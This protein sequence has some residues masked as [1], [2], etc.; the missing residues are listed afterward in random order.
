MCNRR[1]S[2]NPL[3]LVLMVGLSTC[4]CASDARAETSLH[5]LER[6]AK[7]VEKKAGKAVVKA[8]A[9]GLEVSFVGAMGVAYVA[10]ELVRHSDEEDE[11]A[12]LVN[13]EL[14]PEKPKKPANLPHPAAS[15]QAT[16]KPT[17]VLPVVPTAP[18]P[19]K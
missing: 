1:A 11:T 16:A 3:L 17:A 4:V 7:K 2:Q 10:L 8:L 5:R 14:N 19:A 12:S 13:V 9:V 6:K 18:R 15:C